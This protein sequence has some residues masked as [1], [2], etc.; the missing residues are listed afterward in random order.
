MFF[1]V[2]QTLKV[3]LLAEKMQKNGY[4]AYGLTGGTKVVEKYFMD[5]ES[6]S[7]N[8]PLA[9]SNLQLRIWNL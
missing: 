3:S 6:K 2:T 7:F 9:L 8:I 4:T 1:S 5:S